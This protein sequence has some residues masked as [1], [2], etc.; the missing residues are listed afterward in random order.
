MVKPRIKL[1]T[2]RHADGELVSVKA[3]RVSLD[4]YRRRRPYKQ[5]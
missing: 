2:K 5:G 1:K 4:E 3:E